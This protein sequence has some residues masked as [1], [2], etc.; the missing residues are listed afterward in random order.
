MLREELSAGE[1]RAVLGLTPEQQQR[2]DEWSRARLAALAEQFDVDTSASQ[3][4]AS[5]GM[6]IA[7]MLGGLAICAALIL[8]FTRY[9]GYLDTWM[10]LAIVIPAPLV[11]LYGAE[12]MAQRERTGYFTGLLALLALS[13]LV[14]NLVVVG[15]IFNITSTERALLAW[16]VFSILLAYRYGLRLMLVLG[17]LLLVSY[18][19]AAYTSWMGYRWLALYDRPEL[20]LLLGLGVF[21]APF[22]IHHARNT[23]F[24]PLYRLLGALIVLLADLTLAEWG[25]SSWLPWRAA[26][27]ERLYEILGLMLSAG[28]IWLGIRRNWNGLVNTGAVFFTILLFMRLFHWWWEWMPRYVFFAA[29][30]ALGIALVLVFKRVRGRTILMEKESL[31]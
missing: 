4:R 20:F 8:F 31:A 16:G 25:G 14:L 19:A 12:W 13:S 29:I 11:F 1:V 26:S 6:R 9:W 15:N 22:W 23:G 30:G 3:E 17:V 2:F 10:Q 5:W 18:I 27:V 28:T 21:F 7:S 24:P